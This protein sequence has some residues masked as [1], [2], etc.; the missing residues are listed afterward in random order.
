MISAFNNK[1]CYARSDEKLSVG[2]AKQRLYKPLQSMMYVKL[3]QQKFL[4]SN[5]NLLITTKKQH[6]QCVSFPVMFILLRIRL[7]L[8]QQ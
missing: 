4:P 7:N 1:Q 6:Y 3:S 8:N 5:K 2:N